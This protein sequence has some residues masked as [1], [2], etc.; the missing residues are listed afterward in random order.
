MTL[1]AFGVEELNA[2]EVQEIN[3]GEGF[4]GEV[5][6]IVIESAIENYDHIK[7]GLADGWNGTYNPR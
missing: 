2:R 6:K 5:A 1:A 4:W 3:G 7:A